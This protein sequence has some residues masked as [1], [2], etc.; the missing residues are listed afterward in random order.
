MDREEGREEGRK[1]G[2]EEGRRSTLIESIL[3]ILETKGEVPEELRE[4]IMGLKDEDTLKKYLILASQAEN[5]QAF[6]TE[7][8]R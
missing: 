6:Q 8:F 5:V 7:I 1:V 3:C 4:T 2:R